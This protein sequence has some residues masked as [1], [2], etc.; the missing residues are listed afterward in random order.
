MVKMVSVICYPGQIINFNL[1]I[2]LN[3]RYTT[4]QAWNHRIWACYFR[5]WKRKN[6]LV[7]RL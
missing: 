3:N 7:C 2:L 5:I 4:R 6:K 1:V